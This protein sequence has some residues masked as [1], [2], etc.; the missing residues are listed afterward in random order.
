M[1]NELSLDTLDKVSGG[2][3]FADMNDYRFLMTEVR[4]G[5]ITPG[6]AEV[7]WQH[8]MKTEMTPLNRNQPVRIL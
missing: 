5:Q 2:L 7:Q 8:F 4:A 6:Q 1:T 3:T